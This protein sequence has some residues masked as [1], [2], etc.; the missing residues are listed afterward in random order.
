MKNII[1]DLYINKK[2]NC[3][4]TILQAINIQYDLNLD[5][6]NI[7]AMAGFGGGMQEEDICG[8]VSGGVAALSF[9]FSVSLD[10]KPLLK[11][12]IIEFKNKIRNNLGSLDCR[13]IKPS[14]RTDLEG[15]LNVI[16]TGYDLLVETINEHLN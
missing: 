11:S 7:T 2:L 6:K 14:F 12:A 3:A 13:F 8:V 15:C 1:F 9:L 10:E 16:Q 5:S 4:Q